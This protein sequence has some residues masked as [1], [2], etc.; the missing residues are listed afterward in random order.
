MSREYHWVLELPPPFYAFLFLI[1][2]NGKFTSFVTLQGGR[3]KKVINFKYDTE[4]SNFYNFFL[5]FSYTG[6]ASD[7]AHQGSCRN[8]VA[9][10]NYVQILH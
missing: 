3:W 5:I 9:L 4:M 10:E 6:K 7:P 1:F 2:H 8:L